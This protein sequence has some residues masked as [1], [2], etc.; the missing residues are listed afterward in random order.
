M[1]TTVAIQMDPV[2][3]FRKPDDTYIFTRE[4]MARGFDVVF[5][6]PRDLIQQ[7]ADVWAMATPMEAVEWDKEKGGQTFRAT[8]EKKRM[9]LARD[10]DVVLMR[11]EPPFDMLYMT[12]TYVL[13]MLKGK[14]LVTNDPVAVRN[15]PEKMLPMHFPEIMP[16]TLVTSDFEA[17]REFRAQYGDVMLKPLYSYASKGVVHLDQEDRN[18]GSLVEYYLEMH[19]EPVIVQQYLKKVRE[20]EKRIILIE[21]EAVG[22]Y[23]RIPPDNE[24]RTLDNFGG[25]QEATPLSPD[26]RHICNTI[27]PFLRD[28]GLLY[29]GIDVIDGLLTEINVT[30]PGGMVDSN[31]NNNSK[32]EVEFWDAVV[33]RMNRTEQA[34][35]A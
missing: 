14:T 18:F 11:N 23:K 5:F 7:G 21:G 19:P 25:R 15:G 28:N 17:I 30:S 10:V 3:R 26:D 31:R 4:A 8:G 35:C 1:G 13:E 20:G 6:T 22:A 9:D 12:A 34:K 29:A 33:D 2:E 32:L 24:T 16:A 27:G